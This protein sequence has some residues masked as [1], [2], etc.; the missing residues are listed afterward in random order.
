M[1]CTHF[2]PKHMNKNKI[3]L[4]FQNSTKNSICNNYFLP[5]N[6]FKV[7]YNLQKKLIQLFPVDY[8]TKKRIR[9]INR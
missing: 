4:T 2:S 1:F 6:I 8:I 9:Y 7:I 5:L 3:G